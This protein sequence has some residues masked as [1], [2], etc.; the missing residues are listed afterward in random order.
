MGVIAETRGDL[1]VTLVIVPLTLL[2]T[3]L[4]VWFPLS[5]KGN[6]DD[7]KGIESASGLL[8]AERLRRIDSAA[9]PAFLRGD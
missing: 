4:L 6:G 9:L 3:S 7:G 8:H 2:L 5:L 1:G